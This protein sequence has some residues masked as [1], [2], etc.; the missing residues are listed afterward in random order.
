MHIEVIF[1]TICPWC[2]LGKRRLEEALRSRPNIR[3]DISWSAFLLNPHIPTQG[4]DLNDYLNA[5]FGSN[6]R[7]KKIYQSIEV[8]GKSLG[9]DFQFSRLKRI[10]NTLDAHRLVRYYS[11]LGFGSEVVEVL[12]QAHFIRG[13][14]TGNRKLLFKLVEEIGFDSSPIR[15]YLFSDQDIEDIKKQNSRVHHFG[16]NGL[17]AFVIDN[18]FS[19]SGA[20]EPKILSRLIEVAEERHKENFS[21]GLQPL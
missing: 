15:D 6:N 5:K 1:D 17:P 8:L 21:E 2:Y 4:I 9:I 7:A 19:I 18:Q 3:P 10:P 14:D 16:I 12:F 20:Q 13:L 11:R